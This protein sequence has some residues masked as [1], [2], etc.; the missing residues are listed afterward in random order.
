[1]H[2]SQ[3][4]LMERILLLAVMP[5]VLLAEFHSTTPNITLFDPTTTSSP[6][7]TPCVSTAKPT[8]IQVQHVLGRVKVEWGKTSPC[9]GRIFFSID[10]TKPKP[11]CTQSVKI[12]NLGNELCE[13]RRCGKFQ[14]FK[15]NKAEDGYIISKNL[16]V[17]SD[18]C[19]T[20]SIACS[21]NNELLAYK[22]ATGLLLVLVL[23][24]ILFRFAWP[25]YI[26]VRNRFSQKQQNRWIGPTQSQS[27]S[28]HRGQA[29]QL[30][31]N[32]VKGQSYP[33]LERLSVNPSR[34]PSSNRNSDYDSYAYN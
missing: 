12:S 6:T 14:E 11:V 20:M 19:S 17:M 30:K 13:E 27:V 31:N 21:D 7:T 23:T 1:M 16:S 24:A 8:I 2:F 34:E 25:T 15:F 32:T 3:K 33:G 28:Y 10:F 9:Q 26:A 5:V 18:H 4:L 29:G 22:V